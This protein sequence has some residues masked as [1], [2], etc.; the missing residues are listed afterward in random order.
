MTFSPPV[1]GSGLLG[2]I[3]AHFG[4]QN[5]VGPTT[6]NEHRRR[7]LYGV[8]FQFRCKGARARPMLHSALP[9]SAAD[10]RTHAPHGRKPWQCAC[11]IAPGSPTA[12]VRLVPCVRSV[13]TR[14]PCARKRYSVPAVD[15]VLVRINVAARVAGIEHALEVERVV[16]AGRADVTMCSRA[17]SSSRLPVGL[18][19]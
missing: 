19:R 4:R 8:D 14:Q 18:D 5:G 2:R 10:Q 15:V 7:R 13:C 11:C 9:P 17:R 3:R 12:T 6:F 1:L 16:L